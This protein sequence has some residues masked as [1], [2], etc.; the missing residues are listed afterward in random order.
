[1]KIAGGPQPCPLRPRADAERRGR[2]RPSEEHAGST[3]SSRAPTCRHGGPQ[4]RSSTRPPVTS[5]WLGRPPVPR[6]AATG[7]RRGRGVPDAMRAG[8]QETIDAY[9][10]NESEQIWRWGK[11]ARPEIR[12]AYRWS[13]DGEP[14]HEPTALRT[15][16]PSD[17]RSGVNQFRPRAR[18]SA[19]EPGDMRCTWSSPRGRR[20]IRLGATGRAGCAANASLSL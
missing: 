3:Q 19:S 7:T 11:D 4:R 2:A 1:M 15:P 5:I 6:L 18:R 17:L 12:L 14:V 8:V 13:L 9:I 20:V 16:L 10:T